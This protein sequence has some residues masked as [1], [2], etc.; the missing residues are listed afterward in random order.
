[1]QQTTEPMLSPKEVAELLGVTERTLYDW[2]ARSE[3]PTWRR[4][5]RFGH[6]RY[7]PQSVRECLALAQR[8]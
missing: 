2:R 1:M 3:G 4:V 8:A 5:G 6:I 7:D